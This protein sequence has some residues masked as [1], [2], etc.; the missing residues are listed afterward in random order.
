[1]SYKSITNYRLARNK[2]LKPFISKYLVQIKRYSEA[3]L[4]RITEGHYFMHIVLLFSN[5]TDEQYIIETC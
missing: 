5:L 1:M 4:F 3:E 2:D